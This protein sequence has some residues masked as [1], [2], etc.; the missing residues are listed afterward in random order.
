MANITDIDGLSGRQVDRLRGLGIRTSDDLLG[1]GASKKGRRELSQVT[2]IGDRRILE[3]IKRA[4]LLRVP[5]IHTTYSDLLDAV[6]IESVKDLRRRS[7]RKLHAQLTEVN[8][9]RSLV[10]RLPGEQ[11]V[12]EWV[13]AAKHLPVV[14]KR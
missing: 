8:T 1:Y 10:T 5:G 11:Q 2:L 3:W 12:A 13:A 7:P 4:D 14:L 6:G 9:K